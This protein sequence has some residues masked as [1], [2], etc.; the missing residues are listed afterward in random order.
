MEVYLIDNKRYIRIGEFLTD[1]SQSHSRRPLPAIFHTYAQSY[2]QILWI[3]RN[4]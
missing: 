2:P 1:L 3:T 4:H